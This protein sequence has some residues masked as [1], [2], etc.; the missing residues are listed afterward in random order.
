MKILRDLVPLTTALLLCSLCA[1][2]D[3]GV[4]IIF[5][6]RA[7]QL[8]GASHEE[9]WEMDPITRNKT[10]LSDGDVALRR[11]MCSERMPPAA[12]FQKAFSVLSPDGR[13]VAS[14]AVHETFDRSPLRITTV[15]DARPIATVQVPTD[16][17]HWTYATSLAWSPDGS[18]VLA[19]AEAGSSSS[20]FEDYWLLDWTHQIWRY[21]GGGNG[22]RWSPDGS[23]ISWTTARD[24]APLGRIQVWVSHLVLLDVSNSGQQPLTSG[25][26][27]ESDFFWCSS[28]R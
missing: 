7:Y 12:R 22:A 13:R 14:I 3:N 1:A 16:R 27:N 25:I 19:G 4:K 28:A 8:V 21:V 5:R 6:S 10:R 15:N 23:Y 26:S 20:H 9:W 11:S 18:L 17:R 2:E 24:L